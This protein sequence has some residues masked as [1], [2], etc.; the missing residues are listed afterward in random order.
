MFFDVDGAAAGG[1]A[2]AETVTTEDELVG[3]NFSF[4]RH[5]QPRISGLDSSEVWPDLAETLLDGPDIER[6][7][8][9]FVDGGDHLEIL[10]RQQEVEVA[11]AMQAGLDADVGPA[12]SGMKLDLGR[13]GFSAFGAGG[14]WERPLMAA[15]GAGEKEGI[16][17]AAGP[18]HAE[19]GGMAAAR[20]LVGIRERCLEGS[21][22]G[23]DFQGE[24]GKEACRGEGVGF[25]VV[26]Y[27]VR[28]G[29]LEWLRGLGLERAVEPPC[30]GLGMVESGAGV[31]D[32]FVG[33]G[34]EG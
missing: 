9:E 15:K 24:A 11:V 4:C 20:A 19:L 12:F 23:P 13:I 3:G 14:A 6:E 28:R 33:G 10:F 29:R 30:Q 2:E 17:I 1:R 34:D 21:V 25:V 22:G 5:E 8:R 26:R 7:E 18:E 31:A 16:A 32:E 27:G